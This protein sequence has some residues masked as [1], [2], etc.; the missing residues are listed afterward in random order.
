MLPPFDG[1]GYLPPGVHLLTCSEFKKRFGQNPHRI[2][3]ITGLFAL[4]R[5]LAEVGCK[6]VWIG[7]SLTT[8][9]KLPGDFDGCFDSIEIDWSSPNLDPVIADPEAQVA[10]FGGTLIADFMSQFQ[11]HLLTNRQNQPRGIVLLDP[12]ELLEEV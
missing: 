8:A 2:R 9:K 6:Q 11:Q 1:D 5:K 3:L 10:Q 4:A 12:R 7:G